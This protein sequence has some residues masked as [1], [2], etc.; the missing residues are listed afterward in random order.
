M[1]NARQDIKLN[2]KKTDHRI[3]TGTLKEDIETFQINPSKSFAH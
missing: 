3:P 2:L 1:T